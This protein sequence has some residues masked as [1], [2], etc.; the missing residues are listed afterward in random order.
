MRP[1]FRI[2]LHGGLISITCRPRVLQDQ[3]FCMKMLCLAKVSVPG[4]WCCAAAW[5]PGHR[6]SVSYRGALQ[7]LRRPGLRQA[8]T[9]AGC[10]KRQ[11]SPLR[12]AGVRLLLMALESWSP[13]SACCLLP[14]VCAQVPHLSCLF[15]SVHAFQGSIYTLWERPLLA[16]ACQVELALLLDL[17]APRLHLR[18]SLQPGGQVDVPAA[19]HPSW[20]DTL[21][22][23]PFLCC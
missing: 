5:P 17:I 21:L 11:H 6:R 18:L 14:A 12:F 7:Y 16:E 9:S 1:V 3:H 8:Q 2:W 4:L 23:H 15:S 10:W 22:R 20:A 13:Q 19:Q